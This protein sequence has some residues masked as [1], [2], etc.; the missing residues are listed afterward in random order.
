MKFI[1]GLGNPGLKYA[2][3]RHNVG[4]WV[5][6]E[7]SKRL[8]VSCNKD[9]FQALIG[10]THVGDERVMLAKPQTFMNHSGQSV[11]ALTAYYREMQ[12]SDDIVVVYD[13]MDFLP[14][15]LR[16]RRTGSAGGHNGVKSVIHH[17]GTEE[18]PRIRIGIGRPVPEYTVI[19]HVLARFSRDD[20]A[21]VRETVTRAAD[22]VLYSLEHSFDH[23]M[24]QF[25]GNS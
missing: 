25:N 14:G 15:Q 3:T 23:A 13:D 7:L 6:D 8:H 2:D 12:P 5:V 21:L 22:A 19:E 1:V 24:N 16:L 20:Y 10:E 4:F 17:L 11:G 18:F 9:K